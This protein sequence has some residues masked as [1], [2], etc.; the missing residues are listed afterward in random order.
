MCLDHSLAVILQIE[1]LKDMIKKLFSDEALMKQLEGKVMREEDLAHYLRIELLEKRY[2]VVLDDLW[3]I[4]DWI[5]IKSIVF[6]LSNNKGSRIIVTTQ[7]VDLAEKCNLESSRSLIYHHQS[8]GTIDAMRLL[9]RKMRRSEEDMKNDKD[10]REIVIKIVKKSGRLPLVVLTLGGMLS[11]IVASE[12]QSI[13]NQL[14]LELESNQSLE[15][16][17]KMIIL[18][19]NHLPSHLKPCFLYL[20][21]FPRNVEIQIRHLINRWITEGFVTSRVGMDIEA[22]AMSYFYDLVNRGTIQPS[23]VNVEGRVKSCRVHGVIS[24]ILESISR[25]EN[26]VYLTSDIVRRAPEENFHHVVHHGLN[27]PNISMDWS[28]VRS[29]T[30]FGMLP[31]EPVCSA[32]LRMLSVL[33]LQDARCSIT[34]KDINNI[35]LLRRLKYL[36]VRGHS[37][38]CALPGSIGKLH[39]LQYLDARNSSITSLPTEISKLHSLI[40]LRCSSGKIDLDGPQEGLAHILC[41]PMVFTLSGKSGIRAESRGLRVPRGIGELQELRTLDVVDIRRTSRR[42]IKELGELMQLRKLSVVIARASKQKCKILCAAIEKLSSLSSLGVDAGGSSLEWMHYGSSPPP[43]LSS[44][45]LVGCLGEV[46]DWF[47]SL[48]HLVKIYLVGSQLK[49]DKTMELLGTLP[50]LMHIGLH[51]NAY[52]GE[53]LVFACGAFIC[54]RKLDFYGSSGLREVRFEEGTSPHLEKMEFGLCRLESGIIGI[55]YLPRLKEISLGYAV[56]V[57]RLYALQNE[58]DAHPNH[59]MLRLSEGRRDHDL[60]DIITELSSSEESSPLRELLEVGE[61]SSQVVVMTARSDSSLD[62]VKGDLDDD[63]FCSCNSD[64]DDDDA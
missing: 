48:M 43:L 30:L 19:Y 28:H 55:K 18:S 36:N 20:S 46:P 63:D 52:A 3:N 64:D 42:A 14:P 11:T 17:K 16:I 56:K 10:M 15:A 38:I 51:R 1:L 41:L 7:D 59:P 61:S 24:D 40:S 21:I 2:F 62:R 34:Q 44:L 23:R 25:D 4:D 58:V 31:M 6:P 57:V 8:L 60:E 9:L 50:S 53:K 27:C 13:Y 39:G 45:K 33:D 37:D 35:G 12:W 32:Y 22:V 26:F 5:W 54:L 29:F 49:G 47:G